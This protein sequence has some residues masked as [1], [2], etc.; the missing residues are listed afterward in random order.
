MDL[1]SEYT[2]KSYNERLFLKK[3]LPILWPSEVGELSYYF[4]S[5]DGRDCYDAYVMLYDNV[6]KSLISR[7]MIE[8]KIRDIH[9]PDLLLEKKKLDSLKLKSKESGAEIMYI[10]VTPEG[11]FV[12]NLTEMEKQEPFLYKKEEHWKS[13]TNK[14]AGKIVKQVTYLSCFKAVKVSPCSNDLEKLIEENKVVKTTV[15]KILKQSKRSRCIFEDIL[16][17]KD[18]KNG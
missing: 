9:Y 6:T 2:R 14:S 4:T 10:S 13:T 12:F 7:T 5:E 15:E 11:S 16:E 3:I 8:L 1:N 18:L 17:P